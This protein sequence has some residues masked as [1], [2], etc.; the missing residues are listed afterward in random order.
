MKAIVEINLNSPQ[1]MSLLGF[2]ES[3]PYTN[4]KKEGRK[5]KTSPSSLLEAAGPGALTLNE[6]EVK[7]EE[8]IR[9]A[10]RS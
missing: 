5:A 6:A 7:F 1:A 10:Y 3:L 2:L 4:V 8:A 9:K